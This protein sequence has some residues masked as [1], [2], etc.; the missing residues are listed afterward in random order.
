MHVH[1]P[2][3]HTTT[4]SPSPP[5]PPLP[6]PR[7]PYP[8]RLLLTPHVPSFLSDIDAFVNQ[9]L[10]GTSDPTETAPQEPINQSERAEERYV[11]P[12]E[13]KIHAGPVAPEQRQRQDARRQRLQELCHDDAVSFPGKNR[14]FD[15]IPNKELDHLIVDDRHGIIYCY[16]P[17]VWTQTHSIIY[18]SVGSRYTHTWR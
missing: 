13:W 7:T 11:P 18:L 6:P 14:T 16:V 12:R 1:P 15:D 17:K 4:P 2:P 8:T 3:S 10:E 5:L 9:F